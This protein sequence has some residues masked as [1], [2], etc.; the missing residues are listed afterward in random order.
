MLNLFFLRE[1]F[2]HKIVKYARQTHNPVVCNLSDDGVSIF[3]DNLVCPLSDNILYICVWIKEQRKI[4]F[5]V[6]FDYNVE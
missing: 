5:I 2:V 1:E 4:K 3:L 6:R